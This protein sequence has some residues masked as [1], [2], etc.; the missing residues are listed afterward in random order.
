MTARGKKIISGIILLIIGGTMLITSL[1]FG[2]MEFING[3]YAILYSFPISL[4]TLV[5]EKTAGI[6]A[7]PSRT[8]L[9]IWLRVPDC[10]IENRDFQLAVRIIDSK[11][12][13]IIA[14]KNI[15]SSN[16]IRNNDAEGQYYLLGMHYFNKNFLG[17]IQYY[18]KGSWVAPYNGTLVVREPRT[19]SMPL[20]KII[21]LAAGI[22]L[23]AGGLVV[24]TGRNYSA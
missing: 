4:S 21:F 18:G 6:V 13:D 22:V 20:K 17:E 14:W 19:F 16:M 1:V 2:I 12:Q 5:H 10:R 24:L 23:L 15:F 9:S 7:V 11:S 8:L 3:K